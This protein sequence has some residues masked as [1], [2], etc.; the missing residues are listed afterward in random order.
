MR[1]RLDNR[2]RRVLLALAAAVALA[3]APSEAQEAAPRPAAGDTVA[4]DT[5]GVSARGALLRSLVLPGWG[6]AYVGAPGRGAIYFSLEAGSLWMVFKTR[7][8]FAAA[9]EQQG[10][11]RARGEQSLTTT[12]ALVEARGQQVEDWITLAVFLL[13]FS[14]ADAYVAAQLADF[15]DNVGVLPAPAG[16]LQLRARV[17]LGGGR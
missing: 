7:R 10:L 3:A 12:T 1:S 11:L 9:E 14:G 16:G 2:T 13:A 5:G 4:A 6:Q 17:P 8:Q 15:G